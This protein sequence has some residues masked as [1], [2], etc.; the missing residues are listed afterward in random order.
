MSMKRENM[1]MTIPIDVER[2][3]LRIPKK[4][5]ERLCASAELNDRSVNA[6]VVWLIKQYLDGKL[7]PSPILFNYEYPISVPVFHPDYSVGPTTS[8]LTERMLER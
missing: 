7:L 4:L 8:E 3:T 5:Y 2:R 1:R 6:Q